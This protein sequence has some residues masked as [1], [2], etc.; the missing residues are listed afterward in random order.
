[1]KRVLV[2][3]L[4]LVLAGVGYAISTRA[5]RS[6]EQLRASTAAEGQ[7]SCTTSSASVMTA[8]SNRVVARLLNQSA[9]DVYV[10]YAATCS[11]GVGVRLQENMSLS[12][13]RY[14]GAI[15]CITASGTATLARK[16][17]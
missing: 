14:T 17:I 5:E 4:V 3:L 8:N 15:S 11:T 10:C 7:T 13:D 16:E 6:L 1:M 12:E 2:P 9:V